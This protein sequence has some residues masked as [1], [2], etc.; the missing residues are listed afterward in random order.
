MALSHLKLGPLVDAFGQVQRRG[1]V[2]G[3]VHRER[4]PMHTIAGGVPLLNDNSV[5][6]G[7]DAHIFQ[8]RADRIIDQSDRGGF[9]AVFNGKHML[10]LI[11]FTHGAR[12]KRTG[13]FLAGVV[14]SK[15]W[16]AA[17]LWVDWI[18]GLR[19]A[20]CGSSP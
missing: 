5:F 17:V 3:L 13:Q 19:R 11:R 7:L 10:T 14:G 8:K 2:V 18:R 6:I 4:D 20:E 1:K 16:F 9:K 12:D 15:G